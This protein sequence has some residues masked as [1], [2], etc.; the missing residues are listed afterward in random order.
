MVLFWKIDPVG[1]RLAVFQPVREIR[2]LVTELDGPSGLLTAQ[3]AKPAAT[4]RVEIPKLDPRDLRIVADLYRPDS[5]RAPAPTL[6]VLHGSSPYGRR[7]G[8]VRMLGATLAERGWIVVA[9]DARGFG[10]TDDPRVIDAPAS[11]VTTGDMDRTLRYLV[12]LPESDHDRIAVLGHSLGVTHALE[13]ALD[14]ARVAA[15]VLVGPAIYTS[16][17]EASLRWQRARFAA[18]RRLLRP[19]PRDVLLSA[20]ARADLRTYAQGRLAV[21]GHTPTLVVVGAREGAEKLN[22]M[23]VILQGVA[24]PVEYVT[25]DATGHYMGVRTFREPSRVHYRPEMFDPFV[26][27]IVDFTTSHVAGASPHQTS[28]R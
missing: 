8:L 10:E 6:V 25:L 7:A 5:I 13:G 11:W 15:I 4:T 17:E 27:L 20:R 3:R 16:G 1:F 23:A 19:V 26:E 22:E 12:A 9:P 2:L 14:D 24:A 18:D 28:N 21:A